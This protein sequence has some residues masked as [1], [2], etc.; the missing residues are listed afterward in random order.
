MKENSEWNLSDDFLED[1][2]SKHFFRRRC[3]Y[4]VQKVWW[5]CQSKS[6]DKTDNTLQKNLSLCP[7][8]SFLLYLDVFYAFFWLIFSYESS[9]PISCVGALW[10]LIAAPLLYLR[11]WEWDKNR[12]TSLYLQNFQVFEKVQ[13]NTVV[14]LRHT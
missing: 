9:F 3:K 14:S 12:P 5:P 6:N 11:V 4:R 13:I 1:P 7:C 10:P 2:L 8:S